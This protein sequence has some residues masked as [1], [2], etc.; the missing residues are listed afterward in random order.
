MRIPAMYGNY[1][2]NYIGEQT[3]SVE[4]IRLC[5]AMATSAGTG[6]PW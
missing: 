3:F 5:I 6:L 2:K 1:I 4:Y